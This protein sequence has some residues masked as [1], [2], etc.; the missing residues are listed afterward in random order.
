MPLLEVQHVNKLTA[1]VQIEERVA[2]SVDRYAAFIHAG[3]DDVINRALEYVFAKDKDF[4]QHLATNA[5]NHIIPSLQVKKSR[6][7]G[8]AAKGSKRPTSAATKN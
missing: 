5:G 4:Q 1:T 2:A 8:K 6:A 3:A 7:S